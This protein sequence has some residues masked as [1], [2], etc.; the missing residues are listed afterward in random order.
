MA[1]HADS[2]CLTTMGH[3][4]PWESATLI[5]VL[6]LAMFTNLISFV[7]NFHSVYTRHTNRISSPFPQQLRYRHSWVFLV[8]AILEP[9][10]TAG[11]QGTFAVLNWS[12]GGDWP[13]YLLIAILLSSILREVDILISR[14]KARLTTDSVF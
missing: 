14:V 8:L 5:T 1:T 4:R 12:Q 3:L 6:A 2:A 11:T 7:N 9:I 10:V 13:A